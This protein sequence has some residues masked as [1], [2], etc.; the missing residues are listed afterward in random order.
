MTPTLSTSM[1]KTAAPMG[2]PKRAEKPAAMPAMV[3][4]RSSRSSR[5]SSCPS[6]LPMLPPICNAAP[7]RPALPPV[8]WVRTVAM[9]MRGTWRTWSCRA[10]RTEA[11]MN[12]V[13]PSLSMFRM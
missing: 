4:I 1:A 8:R 12:S 5:C 9:K 7:S 13:P 3:I 11:R 10:S 2:V 6:L